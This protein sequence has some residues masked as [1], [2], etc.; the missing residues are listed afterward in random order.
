M[1]HLIE[2]EKSLFHRN[3]TLLIKKWGGSEDTLMDIYS[4]AVY[5]HYTEPTQSQKAQIQRYMTIYGIEA[6]RSLRNK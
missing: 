3:M 4:L 1:S 2:N 6:K 5:D